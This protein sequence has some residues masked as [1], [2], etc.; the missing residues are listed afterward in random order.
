MRHSIPPHPAPSGEEVDL[1][2]KSSQVLARIAPQNESLTLHVEAAGVDEPLELPSRA[3]VLLRDVL[4]AMAA[5]QS[6]AVL[7]EEAELTT[8]EA[9]D[10][11]NVSRPFLI[12]L[13]EDGKIPYRKVGTHRRIRLNDVLAFKAEDDLAREAILDQLARDAQEQDMDYPR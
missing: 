13:L 12:K 7:S 11:L 2:R 3:V 6:V 1:A 4:E 9:A 10:I 8:A 5:G